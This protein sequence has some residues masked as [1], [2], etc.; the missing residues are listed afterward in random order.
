M[1]GPAGDAGSASGAAGRAHSS[2]RLVSAAAERNGKRASPSLALPRRARGGLP[3]P[4]YLLDPVSPR[5]PDPQIY[6]GPDLNFGAVMR[7]QW[8]YFLVHEFD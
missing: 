4:L 6:R 2:S 5:V 7:R 8:D 3:G 1:E